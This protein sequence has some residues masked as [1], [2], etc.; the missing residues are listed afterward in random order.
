MMTMLNEE[1]LGVCG[2]G[3]SIIYLININTRKVIKE[4]KF[5]DFSS[6]YL[7]IS[8]LLDSSIILNNSSNTCIHTKLIKED[9]DYDLKIISILGG[10]TLQL[11]HLNIYLMKYL[12]IHVR[13]D[14]FMLML[15]KIFNT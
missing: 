1:I 6:D 15:T 4:V 10:Y 11:I 2:R 9:N 13:M 7:S 12:Y 5:K 8:T 14:I 3:N